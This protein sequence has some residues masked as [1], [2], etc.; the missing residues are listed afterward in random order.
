[1]CDYGFVKDWRT[2]DLL[3]PAC[4]AARK[5]LRDLEPEDVP[6]DLRRVAAQ[7][8]R[9]L[10][11]PL[12]VKL[13]DTLDENDWLREKTAETDADLDPESP[14]PARAVSALFLLRP[15]GWEERAELAARRSTA[16]SRE[17]L[18]ARLQKKVS[19]LER[20]LEVA[21]EKASAA[22][23][24]ARES[25]AAAE[26]R[27]QTARANVESARREERQNADALRRDHES[28]VAEHRRLEADLDEATER[29]SVLRDEL[30]R[31]RRSERGGGED[32]APRVWGLRDPLSLARL[33]DDIAG[34]VRPEAEAPPTAAGAELPERFAIPPGVAP[35]G[36]EAIRWLLARLAPFSLLVDGYNITFLLNAE[37]F[38]EKDLRERLNQELARFRR[39]AAVP[40]RVTVVYDSAQAGGVTSLTG[41]GGVEVRF[42]EAGRAADE[43]IVALAAAL[44][45]DVVVVSTDRKV[46][47][48][49]E[50]A[51]AVGLWSQALVEWMRR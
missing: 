23:E 8:G 24:R 19:D 3:G 17:A 29:I 21:R 34:A 1:M 26:K 11:P 2:P 43:E 50:E 44:S 48:G 12:A 13:I 25:V 46:R 27:V 14:D 49:S 42:T 28:L 10:P 39:M 47:E 16:G 37:R 30:L 22:Q 31:M 32:G 41:P 18:I 40:V 35:D 9:R 38:Q 51:G 36:A 7:S 4:R 33:L 15:D 6:A 45:G 5:A 20:Q